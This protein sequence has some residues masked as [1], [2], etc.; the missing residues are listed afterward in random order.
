VAKSVEVDEFMSGLEH[1]MAAQVE[2]LRSIILDADPRVAETIKWNAPSFYIDEHFATFSLRH[3][4]RLRVV[5][6]TGAKVNPEARQ[7]EIDDPDGLLTWPSVDRAIITFS[8][9]DD[10]AAKTDEF[11]SIVKQW[12]QQTT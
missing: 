8:H 2:S 9:P 7:V 3:P 12:I 11:A 10:V 5:L 1:P 6:H 4:D